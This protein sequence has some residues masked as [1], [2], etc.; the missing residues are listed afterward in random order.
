MTKAPEEALCHGGGM[1]PVGYSERRVYQR[2][3]MTL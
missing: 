1:L 2:D 3:L